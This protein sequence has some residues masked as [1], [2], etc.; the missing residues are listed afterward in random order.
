MYHRDELAVRAPNDMSLWKRFDNA[1]FTFYAVGLGACGQFS[2]PGDF[3]VALNSQ[4]FG[5]GGSCF[6][7]ITIT[8]NGKTAQAQIM[9][10]CPGCPYAGL[11]F[12]EG[13]FT[14]FAPESAG[15]LYGT[16]VFGAGAPSPS[17]E[18]T[19]TWQPP[20]TTW[21]PPTTTWSPP[22]TTSTPEPT[23]TST[24]TSTTSSSPPTTT[25]NDLVVETPSPSGVQV[26]LSSIIN[27]LDLALLSIGGLLVAS[28]NQ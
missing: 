21:Q 5:G 9:D 18:P 12:S 6:Q 25:S 16:W 19:T 13:L 26:S 15:V 28:S 3:I 27:E 17:P 20:T 2:Q 7:V 14:Y 4:Q 22:A 11:D 24:T 10:E 1:R 23:T 8:I